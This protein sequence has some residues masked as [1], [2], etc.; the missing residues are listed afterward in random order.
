MTTEM[1]NGA[2]EGVTEQT[3]A[4][5][6]ADQTDAQVQEGDTGDD[7]AAATEGEGE[8]PR[9]RKSA[10]ERIDELT[11]ARREAE[12]EAE[13]WRSKAMEPAKQPE[14]RQEPK[15]DD[16]PDPATYE[17]GENDLRYIRDLAKYEAR[18]EFRKQAEEDAAA[19]QAQEIEQGY[20]QREAATAEKYDDYQKAVYRSQW[21]CTPVMADAIKTSEGGP[22]VAY[23]LA[24]NPAEA[25]R[26]AALTPIAQVREIT[27]LEV[28]LTSAPPPKTTT[29]APEPPPQARGAGG[30]FVVSPDTDDFAAF[31]KQY[32]G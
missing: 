3:A 31:D 23:H 2:P 5:L 15:G 32:S 8:S 11:R 16:E 18:Q 20:A 28:K 14:A 12:R 29:S 21:V 24:K 6:V 30:K 7:A 1:T 25:R 10:Q 26:I 19:R 22:E 17:Y 13:Y 27:R 9:P 4:D